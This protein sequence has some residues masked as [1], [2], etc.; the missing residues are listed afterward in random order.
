MPHQPGRVPKMLMDVKMDLDAIR[1]RDAAV[2]F[3]ATCGDRVWP[4]EQANAHAY[5]VDQCEEML[6]SAARKAGRE[7]HPDPD[8][9]R[10]CWDPSAHH[11]FVEGPIPEYEQEL[12]DRRAL[13]A[14]IPEPNEFAEV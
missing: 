5:T 3:C 12:R 7:R 9:G 2:H 10:L 6:R 4:G 8:T 1:A 11:P 13:L 14:L